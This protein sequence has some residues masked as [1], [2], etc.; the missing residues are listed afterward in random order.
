MELNMRTKSEN[1]YSPC[2]FQM[3]YNAIDARDKRITI[4]DAYQLHHKPFFFFQFKIKENL[5]FFVWLSFF[6]PCF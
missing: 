3:C 6:L 2:C 1:Q 4:N 5:F